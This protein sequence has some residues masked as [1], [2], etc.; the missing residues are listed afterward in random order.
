MCILSLY[1]FHFMSAVRKSCY[2]SAF[3]VQ[4]LFCEILISISSFSDFEMHQENG[5]LITQDHK[6]VLRV[7][8]D[9]NRRCNLCFLG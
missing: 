6:V 8:W 7:C 4:M 3:E 9:S 5:A 2:L 1:R